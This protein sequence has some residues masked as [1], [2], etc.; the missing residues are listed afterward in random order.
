MPSCQLCGN[1]S[2]SLS[3]VKIEGATM[4]VCDSCSDLGEEVTTKSKKKPK[5]TKK[6]SRTPSRR[7]SQVLVNNY[8]KKVK[9]AR[10]DKKLSLQEL[11]DELKE[12]KSVIQ[13]IEQSEL[14]P[15]KS[16]AG[17]ISR[18]LGI[19]LYTNPKT[20]DEDTDSGDTRK[21]TL[22]DVADIKE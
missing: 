4:K 5:K 3:K 6:K 18:E 21:A 8:G 1:D 7:E 19:E 14:K 20:Y 10:E 17:K 12:K 2:D 9:E 16:L 11:A 13:K 22:G 15:D